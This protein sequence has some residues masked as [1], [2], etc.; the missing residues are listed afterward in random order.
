MSSMTKSS[1]PSYILQYSSL[2]ISGLAFPMWSGPDGKGAILITIFPFSAFGNSLSPSRISR[3]DVLTCSFENS[4]ICVSGESLLTSFM[5][6][7]IVGMMSFI[8]DFS[9]PSANRPART[10]LWFASPLCL[11]AFSRA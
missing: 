4:S 8:F 1:L 2:R 3:F 5:T 6:F 10:A 7:W 11:I 9:N